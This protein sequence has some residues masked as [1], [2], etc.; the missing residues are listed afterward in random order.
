LTELNVFGIVL[1]R[2]MMAARKVLNLAF[3]TSKGWSKVT[4]CNKRNTQ[5]KHPSMK[6]CACCCFM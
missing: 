2:Q 6:I 5:D 1:K 4:C 3:V